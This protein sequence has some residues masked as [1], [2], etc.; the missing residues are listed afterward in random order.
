MEVVKYNFS[1]NKIF[2]FF[3]YYMIYKKYKRD[4]AIKY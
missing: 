1:Y 2:F 4:K 3:I